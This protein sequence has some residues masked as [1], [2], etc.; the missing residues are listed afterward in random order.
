MTIYHYNN[1]KEKQKRGYEVDWLQHNYY[2][3]F[4]NEIERFQRDLLFSPDKAP[5]EVKRIIYQNPYTIVIWSDGKKTIVKCSDEDEYSPMVGCVLCFAKMYLF[6]NSDHSFHH[7]LKTCQESIDLGKSISNSVC[8]TD[9]Y[10]PTIG[11]VISHMREH[12]FNEDR[13]IETRFIE[14]VKKSVYDNSLK[15]A[16]EKEEEKEGEKDQKLYS[17]NDVVDAIRSI[18]GIR[19]NDYVKR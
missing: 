1:S 11:Y 3:D 9:Y 16:K 13:T 15:A 14:Y 18:Y 12:M 10:D 6:D 2:K 8:P 19:S 5:Q 7:F 17:V 4:L